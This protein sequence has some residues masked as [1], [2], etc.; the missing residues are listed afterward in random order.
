[1]IATIVDFKYVVFDF[2]KISMPRGQIIPICQINDD[3][4]GTL[5]KIIQLTG[6]AVEAYL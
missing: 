2:D 4:Y 3:S 1:M 5:L 6:E